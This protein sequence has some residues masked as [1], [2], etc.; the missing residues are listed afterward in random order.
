MKSSAFSI[1]GCKS[2]LKS[3]RRDSNPGL[4]AGFADFTNPWTHG[5][6]AEA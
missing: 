3:E 5:W 1:K 2:S 6:I 4:V